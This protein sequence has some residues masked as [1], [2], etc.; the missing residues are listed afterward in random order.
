MMKGLGALMI[1]VAGIMS[2][3]IYFPPDH[4]IHISGTSQRVSFWLLK[5][6]GYVVL[7]VNLYLYEM[8]ILCHSPKWRNGIALLACYPLLCHMS[9]Q[10]VH[11]YL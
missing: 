10:E 4:S 1:V 3:A 2:A 5:V 9:I 11:Q 7:I 6:C 8:G